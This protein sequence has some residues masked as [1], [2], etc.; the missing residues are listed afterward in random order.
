M[1][2][3]MPAQMHA[4]MPAQMPAQMTEFEAIIKSAQV[5]G[6]WAVDVRG[7]KHAGRDLMLT[8]RHYHVN[9]ARTDAGQRPQVGARV[10]GRV[11]S[12]QNQPDAWWLA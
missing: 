1:P 8:A 10:R 12:G 7:I 6:W 9:L 2:A 11:A 3:Q 5:W 4:Q